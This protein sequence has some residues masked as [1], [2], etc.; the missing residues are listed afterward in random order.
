MDGSPIDAEPTVAPS[1]ARGLKHQHFDANDV[2]DI[3]APSR[4]R[5]LKPTEAVIDR[6][7]KRSRPH[8]RVD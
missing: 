3:V 7:G 1:R 2:A 4:A 6:I 8:G 5:G